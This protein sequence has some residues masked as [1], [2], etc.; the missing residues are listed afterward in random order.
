MATITPQK[1]GTEGFSQAPKI[2][3]QI[4]DSY[5]SKPGLPDWI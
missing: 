3:I 1:L 5:D 4:T 2:L